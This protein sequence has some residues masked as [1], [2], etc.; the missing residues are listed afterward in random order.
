MNQLRRKIRL[1]TFQVIIFSFA[2]VI[3]IGALLLCLPFAS[4]D[5]CSAP[6]A[7]ALF[8]STSAVCVTGLIVRDTWRGWTVFGRTV[9]LLLIQAGGMGVVTI[10]ILIS[11][12]SGR[13]ISLSQRTLMKEAISAEKIGGIVRLTSFILK[14]T[15]AAEGL[16]ALFL[17]P[18]FCRRYGAVRGLGFAVFHSVSAFC[19]AGFDLCGEPEPFSSLTAY[20]ASV[21]VN[22]TV[23]LLIIVGGLGF[24]TWEDIGR[25][26]QNVGRY[27]LQTKVILSMTLLLIFLP[28][29]YFYFFEFQGEPL[30]ERIL[31]SLFQA[32]TPRTAGFNTVDETALSEAGKMV[33]IFLMLIGGA[34]GSTAGGMKTTTAAVLLASAVAVFRHRQNAEMF[35]RRVEAEVIRKAAAL[36]LM[37]LLLFLSAAMVISRI[38]S[39]PLLPCLFETASAIG[40]VGLT[41][42]LTPGLSLVSKVILMLLMFFGRVGGL[43]IMFAAVSYRSD[44][45]TLPREDIAVG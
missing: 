16:G 12:F 30:G 14:F 31:A 15:L 40:T 38:E 2:S 20:A 13:K 25:H 1:S 42:G 9:I 32:V 5:G 24:R 18:T 26:R 41:L 39:L 36:L 35:R 45:V 7:D 17:A 3:L 23:M 11:L 34:P 44:C 21:P 33:I 4:R 8:T 37:Y 27:Q 22:I 19:N 43:T 10:A 28:A 29:L 6:F